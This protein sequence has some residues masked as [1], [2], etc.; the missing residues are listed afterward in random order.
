MT[1]KE[2]AQIVREQMARA[3]G[4]I[5]HSAKLDELLMPPREISVIVRAV[6]N[7]DLKDELL[8]VWL[9]GA[10]SSADGYSIVMRHDGASFGLASSGFS[11]DKFMVLIGWYGDLVSAF[12][13]M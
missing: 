13:G 4:V 10:E 12:A 2:A 5:S 1:Q 8:R 6:R 11:S 3:S 7:G 9:I